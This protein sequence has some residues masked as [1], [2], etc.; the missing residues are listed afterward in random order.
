M[1][2]EHRK[3]LETNTLADRMGQAMQ[4]V[5]GG[6][7]STF[8]VYVL[9]VVALLIGLWFFYATMTSSRQ[10]TSYRWLRLDD[11][12]LKNLDDLANK[13]GTTPAGKA[14]RLQI[15]WLLYWEKGVKFIGTDPQ[16]S[17]QML[18]TSGDLYRKLAEDCKDDP[19]YEPQALLG[20]AVVEE[21]KAIQDRD[22]L[23]KAEEAYKAVI[24]ANEGKYK[25][26]VEGK[27]AQGR[28]EQLK[29]NK[30][31]AEIVAIYDELK[32]LM[33]IP[34]IQQQMPLFP[35]MGELPPLPGKK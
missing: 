19:L 31:R 10:E 16:G 1:K 15:A 22:F 4:R 17:L 11:G 25:D 33:R 20:I 26:T 28:I 3:V 7:R 18:K 8:L 6:R 30:K 5:K 34:A 14:A 2:A 21:S 12:G 35:P 13:E 32:T 29:D 9:V 23:K 24:E 27:F